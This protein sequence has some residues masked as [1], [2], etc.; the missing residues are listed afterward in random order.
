MSG[1]VAA[2]AQQGQRLIFFN[3]LLQQ[4]GV[5]LPAEPTLIVAGSLAGRG[6]LSVL[7]IGAAALVATLVADLIWFL[8]GK[9]FGA[10]ALRL[11]YR[12]SSSP[13]RQQIQTERLLSRWGPAAFAFA[14]FIPGLPMSG[15]I[16]A[17]SMGTT[18][19]VFLACDLLA[20]SLWAGGFTMLGLVFK[21]DVDRVLKELDH[22]GGWVLVVAAAVL[23]VIM[24][25]RRYAKARS[26]A[27][28]RS[29]ELV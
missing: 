3:V 18:L 23:V 25:A 6:R 4:I 24:V 14:K 9:R 16:L 11:V 28:P 1:L 20:M 15:P 2:L 10:R 5:P 22:L 26:T 7:D 17:G 12:L 27:R 19:P 13:E 8:V 21:S 29:P